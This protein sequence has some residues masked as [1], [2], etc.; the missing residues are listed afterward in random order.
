VL[1][2][3]LK[4]YTALRGITYSGSKRNIWAGTTPKNTNP[5]ETGGILETWQPTQLNSTSYYMYINTQYS[6]LK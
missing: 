5:A 2:L 1:S 6:F 3:A 4:N